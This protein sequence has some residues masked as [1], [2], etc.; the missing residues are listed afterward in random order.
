[1][2][3]ELQGEFQHGGLIFINGTGFGLK[4]GQAPVIWD[5]VDNQKDYGSLVEDAPIPTQ[6]FDQGNCST[7]PWPAQE[8]T[9][10]NNGAWP[11]MW[12]AQVPRHSRT[13]AC[14]KIKERGALQGPSSVGGNVTY[15]SFWMRHDDYNGD[16]DAGDNLL[17]RIYAGND[18][19]THGGIIFRYPPDADHDCEAESGINTYH[20]LA[21]NNGVWT[22]H[23]ILIS[24][25]SVQSC[26]YSMVEMKINGVTT[27]SGDDLFWVNVDGPYDFLQFLGYWNRYGGTCADC[28]VYLD[29]IYL[30][31]TYS[32]VMIGNQPNLN[33]CT[34]LEMQSHT[35]WFDGSP[36]NDAIEITFNQG[37][38]G[39]TEDFYI[40]VV[41][42]ANIANSPGDG[43]Y[44]VN[45]PA[46]LPCEN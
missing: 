9:T 32:R 25:F 43:P 8:S 14:M 13:T 35:L 16:T 31:N 7:C 40:F 11:V 30:D 20:S 34:K 21:D 36:G 42:Y 5:M 22:F 6:D 17:A 24:G 27:A 15:L 26:G 33:N 18:D 12:S 44:Q 1:L 29:D 46:P 39:D 45:P 37:A 2:I 28:M 23:E 41:D 19:I 10:Y 38:F 3:L 4:L